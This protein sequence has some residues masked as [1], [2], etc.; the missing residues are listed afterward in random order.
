MR[1]DFDCTAENAPSNA[2]RSGVEVHLDRRRALLVIG[3]A[4]SFVAACSSDETSAAP[5]GG[6]GGAATGAAGNGAAGSGAAGSGAAGSAAGGA[7]A[8]ATGGTAA[9]AASY[10]D[11]FATSLGEACTLT[12]F[13]TLGPCYA[14]TVERKDIS[15]GYPGLP[16]RLSLLVI[17]ASCTPLPGVSVDI[18]HTRN[19]GLYSGNDTGLNAPAFGAPGAA[20]DAG[21]PPGPGTPPPGAPAGSDAGPGGPPGGFSCTLEDEDA[22]T[23]R[24]FRGV[25]TT[26]AR[27]RVDFDTC[28]PGWYPGRA[29]H[30]HFTVRRNG[31]EYVTSQLYY[32]EDLTT[33]VLGS[34]PDYQSFGQP[35][36]TNS[37][38][39][40]FQGAAEVLEVQRQSDGALLAYKTL[41]LR[42]ALTE[43]LCG[44][45]FPGGPLPPT[46]G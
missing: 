43:E 42:S 3:S 7:V 33:E 28:Y 22:K 18:W 44:S 41:V 5:A 2:A 37:T 45:D 30:I 31:Q 17:D 25:Q 19:S 8:F 24:F 13:S 1:D 29:L 20:G 23:H 4:V 10:P 34:H 36:T 35:N 26:D 9:L 21:A 14:S 12:C 16:V 39:S 6:S 32:P 46:A 40:I 38:D 15:E 11:P 27:G